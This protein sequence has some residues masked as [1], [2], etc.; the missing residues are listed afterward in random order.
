MNKTELEV[1]V[2]EPMDLGEFSYEFIDIGLLYAKLALIAQGK[3]DALYFLNDIPYRRRFMELSRDE[4]LFVLTLVKNSPV[5]IELGGWIPKAIR[6][7]AELIERLSNLSET[8]N[9]ARL[10][11]EARK[12]EIVLQ[13]LEKVG[14]NNLTESQGIALANELLHDL[15]KV[16]SHRKSLRVIN[17]NIND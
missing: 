7:L 11:N 13:T 4:K 10:D 5:K 2:P 9:R 3:Y 6:A 12:I 14:L 1:H 15:T 8:R 17:I 16:A